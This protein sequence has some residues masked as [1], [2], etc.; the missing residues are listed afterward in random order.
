MSHWSITFWQF[1]NMYILWLQT[2]KKCHLY[3]DRLLGGVS[4]LPVKK[5]C[6][7]LHFVW[8]LF[9]FYHVRC[10]NLLNFGHWFH[11]WGKKKKLKHFDCWL[12]SE[13]NFGHVLPVILYLA[14]ARA[15][16]RAHYS[17][18]L[19]EVYKVYVMNHIFYKKF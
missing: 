3:S 13:R 9:I 16:Q 10:L 14:R 19:N 11:F 17:K 18:W 15:S 6:A 2:K 12:I 5:F 1:L 7:Y 4:N 8:V